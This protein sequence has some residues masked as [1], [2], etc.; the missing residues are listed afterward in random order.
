MDSLV[1]YLILGGN[2]PFF[3]TKYDV[4]CE[5]FT[6]ALYQVEEVPFYS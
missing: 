5:F 4:S 3:T 6:D 2:I 1:L